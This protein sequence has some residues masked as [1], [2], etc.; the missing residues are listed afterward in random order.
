[1]GLVAVPNDRLSMVEKKAVAGLV[2]NLLEMSPKIWF[3]TGANS[4]LG[5]ALAICGLSKVCLQ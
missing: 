3:V 1:M 4:G 5:L 2:L